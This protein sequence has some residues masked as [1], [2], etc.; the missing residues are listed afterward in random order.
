[1]E[2][3]REIELKFR[4]RGE[5][6]EEASDRLIKLYERTVAP[7]NIL[8][9][10]WSEDRYW[11]APS[12][13]R[14]D[15]VRLRESQGQELTGRYRELMEVTTKRKDRGT[16]LNRSEENVRLDVKCLAELRG[17]LSRIL[18]PDDGT[19][20]KDKETILF[21]GGSLVVSLMEV[22][23]ELFLEVEGP[24]E[25]RV[26]KEAEKLGRHFDLLIEPAS[27]F[28]LFIAGP[29]RKPVSWKGVC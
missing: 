23:G 15:F 4:V 11:K 20:R 1:M 14:V 10:T 28:E 25:E 5:S 18:G 12:S 19:V 16:N 6:F 3:G 9:H 2:Y 13:G 29:K 24:T 17:L 27:F 22:R 8:V 26:K 21:A 7:D